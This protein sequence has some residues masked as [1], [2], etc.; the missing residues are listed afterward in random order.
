MKKLF[1]TIGLPRSGKSSWSM[2]QGVPVVNPDAIRLVIHGQAFVREA[3]PMVWTIAKYMVKAL[4]T[5]GHDNVIVDATNITRKRRD[6]WNGREWGVEC[7]N[8]T[9]PSAL[10]LERA[11]TSGR[12][13]LVP[14]IKRMARV[15]TADREEGIQCLL[16]PYEAT[17]SIKE[18][19]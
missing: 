6:E 9:T 5:A 1:L 7:V 16:T 13:D 2:K 10:C 8:F 14:V 19:S 4:F 15:S 17:L 18:G 11:I 3:E 12:D